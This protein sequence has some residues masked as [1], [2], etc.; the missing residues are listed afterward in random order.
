MPNPPKYSILGFERHND[1]LTT[2]CLK[3]KT[4]TEKHQTPNTDQAVL[5]ILGWL[6]TKKSAT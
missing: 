2:P 5:P 3:P 6:S 4:F 1:V